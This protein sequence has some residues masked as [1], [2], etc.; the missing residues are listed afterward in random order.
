MHLLDHVSIAVP[1]IDVARP[2]Y[3]AVFAALGVSKVYDNADALGYGQ[4]CDAADD[5]HSYLS[6]LRSPAASADPARHWCF[7]AASRTQ[8]E[9][10]HAAALAH[11]GSDDGGPGLR[12]HY[13]PQYFA[14]FVRDPFG[15]R[16]EAVCHRPERRD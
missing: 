12:P 10:F 7:K 15:N 5:A 6:I 2:F 14:A 3:D 1:D 9:A 13:H 4:R 8:V 11:G 16:L